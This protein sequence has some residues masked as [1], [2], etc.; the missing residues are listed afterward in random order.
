MNNY[1]LYGI[2]IMAII[3]YIIRVLPITLFQKEIKSKFIQ[4]FLYYVPYAVLASLTFPAI[5][6]ATGNEITSIAGTLVAL[7]LAYFNKGLV[8][9]A[10]GAVVTALVISF[11]PL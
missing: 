9:V 7:I 1:Y 5:F 6:T 3:T 8:I 2:A 10:I 4:S 11:F